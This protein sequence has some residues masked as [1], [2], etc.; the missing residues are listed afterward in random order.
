MLHHKNL[1][2]RIRPDTLSQ[3]IGQSHCLSVQK[4]LYNII[5]NNQIESIIITGPPGTGKT[6]LAHIISKQPLQNSSTIQV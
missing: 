2:S 4:P 1:A 5:N 6:S 3:F